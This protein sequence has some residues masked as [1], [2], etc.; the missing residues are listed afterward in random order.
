MDRAR[1]EVRAAV[2]G[3]VLTLDEVLMAN[4]ELR[5][6]FKQTMNFGWRSAV[7]RLREL[8]KDEQERILEP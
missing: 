5:E 6:M 7:S 1:K 2:A 8:S 4:P 3:T